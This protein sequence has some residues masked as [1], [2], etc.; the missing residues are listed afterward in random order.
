MH[1]PNSRRSFLKSAALGAAALGTA[2]AAL[3]ADPPKIQ[4]FEEKTA[5]TPPAAEWKPVSDRKIRMGI[6]GY[7]VC[8]FG[9]SSRCRTIQTSS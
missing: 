3:A 2:R 1:E 9:R 8:Q 4:G 6:V 5:T 7:G